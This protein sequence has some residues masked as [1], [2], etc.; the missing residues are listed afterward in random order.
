MA[1]IPLM[2]QN[3]TIESPLD[4][5]RKAMSLQQLGQ[6]TQMNALRIQQAQQQAKQLQQDQQDDAA[7]RQAYTDAVNSTQPGKPLDMNALSNTIAQK[8]SPRK[9]QTWAK[10]VED[11]A[12]AQAKLTQD[13]INNRKEQYGLLA[14]HLGAVMQVKPGDNSPDAVAARAAE[15][16][17]QVTLAKSKGLDPDNQLTTDYPGDDALP[18]YD[19]QLRG[20]QAHLATESELRKAKAEQFKQQEAEANAPAARRSAAA[21]A[22]EA[23]AKSVQA[24]VQNA[25]SEL[26]QQSSPANYILRLSALPKE[27]AAKFPQPPQGGDPN[28]PLSDDFRSQVLTAGMTPKDRA[29]FSE[30]QYTN[31][32]RKAHWDALDKAAQDRNARS[33]QESST[34]ANLNQRNWL[35]QVR[36]LRK[37]ED[38]TYEQRGNVE[39]ALKS[40]GT[41]D[42]KGK[43]VS[44]DTDRNAMMDRLRNQFSSLTNRLKS[45]ATQK[46][47]IG[48]KLGM[49]IQVP[50]SQIHKTLDADIERVNGYGKTAP[51]T[52]P[53]TTTPAATPAPAKQ[54]PS[55]VPGAAAPRITAQ[56][57]FPLPPDKAAKPA[58]VQVAPGQRVK[59]KSGAVV[60]V[61]Q[62]HPDG[63]F[64]YE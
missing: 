53:A 24:Q 13:Q 14:N 32:L 42:E 20:A 39:A 61:T 35:G 1:T 45:I 11:H 60:K 26:S 43:P 58:P 16:A 54:A 25:A 41:I 33:G 52:K 63:T 36:N 7:I 3:P 38:D 44:A 23:E 57:P 12:A 48:E 5:Q 40:G 22:T 56:T 29:A 15:W 18:A 19:V 6:T 27:V 49:N 30:Q 59:L 51:A 10:A 2:F 9:Y 21:K 34:Q 8:V 47:D 4:A 37:E 50:T 55:S 62:V 28:A 31:S 46:N 17:K 64:D